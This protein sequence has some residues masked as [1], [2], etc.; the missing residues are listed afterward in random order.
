M[1]HTFRWIDWN[2]DHIAEHGVSIQEAEDVVDTPDRGFPQRVGDDKRLVMG[3]TKIGRYIQVIYV[4]DPN[5]TIFVIH[6]RPLDDTEK[7]ALRRR[8]RR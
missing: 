8:R 2:I 7:R 1:R 5:G 6:A 3:Q 4:I